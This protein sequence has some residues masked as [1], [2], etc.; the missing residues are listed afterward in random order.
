MSGESGG[1]LK[2]SLAHRPDYA[3]AVQESL[4]GWQAHQAKVA[5]DSAFHKLLGELA[6]LIDGRKT[7][8]E[9]V[10]AGHPAADSFPSCAFAHA[11]RLSSG[12][13]I[14]TKVFNAFAAS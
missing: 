8:D 2:P 12:A 14:A 3:F 7:S 11:S 10:L 4:D 1:Y 13:A 5:P 9:I 6:P